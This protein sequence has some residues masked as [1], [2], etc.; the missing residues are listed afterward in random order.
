MLADPS[1][2]GAHAH[3]KHGSGFAIANGPR[4]HESKLY[5]CRGVTESDTTIS[6]TSGALDPMIANQNCH[7]C[8]FD[9]QSHWTLPFE[10]DKSP[11][12][13]L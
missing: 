4:E 8:R 7:V 1:I 12:K 5:P 2:Q 3:A 11:G 6:R 10:F 9:L 13:R